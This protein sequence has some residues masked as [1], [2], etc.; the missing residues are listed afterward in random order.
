MPLDVTAPDTVQCLNSQCC[1]AL[2]R[3]R[4]NA[5]IATGTQNGMGVVTII[6]RAAAVFGDSLRRQDAN[7]ITF[8]L[9]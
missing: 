9:Q 4:G 1:S 2:D 8:G 5:G 7:S 3:Y 6:L